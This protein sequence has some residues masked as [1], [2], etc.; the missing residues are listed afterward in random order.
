MDFI[1]VFIKKM[2]VGFE[3]DIFFYIIIPVITLVIICGLCL[4]IQW[5]TSNR[6]VQQTNL[7]NVFIE[8]G[9]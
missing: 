8:S 2:I 1:S 6:I 7:E 3:R 5:K 9:R 4:Y